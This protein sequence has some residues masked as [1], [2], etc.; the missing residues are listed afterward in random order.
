MRTVIIV[1]AVAVAGSTVAT[2]IAYR[3]HPTPGA[4]F[5]ALGWLSILIAGYF[6]ARAAASFDLTVTGS[7]PGALGGGRRDE[8]E[9]EKKLLLKAI[10]ECE[11]DR[12]T[13]KLD[14]GEAAS[15]IRRYRARAVEILRLLDATPARKYEAAIESELARRLAREQPRQPR[16]CPACRATNDDDAAFGK[17]CGAK[18]EVA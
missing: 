2:L 5:L 4:V 10:K 1:G 9:R 3:G 11:F 13:G 7:G 14:S 17:K 6:L 15:A 8:L 12:D 18:L 16:A